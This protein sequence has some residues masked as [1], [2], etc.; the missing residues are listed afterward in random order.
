MK[1]EENM[2][3]RIFFICLLCWF[4]AGLATAQDQAGTGK[5]LIWGRG[6]DSVTLD[7]AFAADGESNKVI[8]N[9]FEGL[10][11]YK[12]NTSDIEPALALSW[13]NKS[14]GKEW[15]FHLRKGVKFHDGTDFNSESVVYSI[16]RQTDPAHPFYRK[17]FGAAG[18]VFQYIRKVESLD[19]YTVKI[20]LEK[21]FAPFLSNLGMPDAAP[22]ASPEA[23]K[24]WGDEFGK[25]PVGTGPFV[26]EEWIPGDRII[27]KKN[28]E[29]WDNP[30]KLERLIFKSIPDNKNRLLAL[31]TSAIHGMDGVDPNAVKEIEMEKNL[32][33]IAAPG[34]NVGYLA[35][36][37]EKKPFDRI[38]VRQ[39]VNY[40]INKQNLV[41]LFYKGLAVPAKNPLPPTVWGANEAV[42]DYEY[43][44]EK[45][46]QLLKEE[47]LEK[48][49][50][51]TLSV[52]TSP[53]PYMPEPEKIARAI[54]ANLA[55]VGIQAEIITS[56]WKTYTAKAY[57]GE[58]EMCLLGWSGDNGD[59]DNFLYVLLDQDNTVKPKASNVS[60]LRHE[61]LHELLVKAREISD[62]KER[63]A[64]YHK[65]QEIIHEQA[66]WAP[67]AHAQRIGVYHKS[68]Q[69]VVFHPTVSI[70]FY[71]LWI[72]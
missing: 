34:L 2:L 27:L 14:E 50:S 21:P 66:P 37:T 33:L 25:H 65:A 42:E 19:D 62:R 28:T 45:A 39:A 31:K 43:N 6:N 52:M 68:V 55:E 32:K 63:T 5:T 36:N 53:R 47:G 44:P 13:E 58:H 20:T 26:F 16:S 67:L 3:K 46:R 17:N 7:P 49:F 8:I 15:V 38:K 61:G 24:K 1:K 56:E 60:F 10:V 35:M 23:L 30:P 57:N 69:G 11:R 59:P 48:G 51:T 9:I 18:F 4:C 54:K 70:K 40:A 22:I 41:K 29:Y 72:E 64:L 12:D 71:R